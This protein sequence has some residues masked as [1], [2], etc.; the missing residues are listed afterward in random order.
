[1]N[2]IQFMKR[3]CRALVRLQN[4]VEALYLKQDL[5]RDLPTK[6]DQYYLTEPIEKARLTMVLKAIRKQR[7]LLSRLQE[8]IFG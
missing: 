3:R 1:M 8:W 5:P 7:G 4:T 2:D 6:D